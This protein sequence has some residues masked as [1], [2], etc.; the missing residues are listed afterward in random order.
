MERAEAERDT[1]TAERDELKVELERL[2]SSGAADAFKRGI[3]H[4]W[5]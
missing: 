5:D 1:L 3:V 2:K 4:G